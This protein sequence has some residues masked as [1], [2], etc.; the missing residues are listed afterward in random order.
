MSPNFATISRCYSTA[1]LRR[2]RVFLFGNYFSVS[3]VVMEMKE[4]GGSKHAT[5]NKQHT[6]GACQVLLGE[7]ITWTTAAHR[8]PRQVGLIFVPKLR[9]E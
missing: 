5:M 6:D 9:L 8:T 3:S 2:S 4:I 7:R 1:D